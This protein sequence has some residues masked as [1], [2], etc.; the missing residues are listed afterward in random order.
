MTTRG[1]VLLLLRKE[2]SCTVSYLSN[3]LQVTPNAIRQHLSALERDYLV[4]QQPV[5]NG[6]RKP[7]LSYSL[8]ARAESLFPNRYSD[9][10]LDC[11][12]ELLAKEGSSQVG[13]FLSELGRSAAEDYLDRL[14]G[15][16]AEGLVQEVKRIMEERGSLVELEEVNAE[17]VLRDFNC[18]HAAVTRAHPEAGQVQRAF[19]HRLLE[20]AR[21]EVACDQQRSRC[22]F[23][24]QPSE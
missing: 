11:V 18:P 16:P 3:Q 1:K 21:V 5:R 7:A 17:V 6:A 19:L 23:R 13:D 22:V 12:Q 8:A 9:L 20:P 15:A 24:I 2:G 4:T 10:L 14:A